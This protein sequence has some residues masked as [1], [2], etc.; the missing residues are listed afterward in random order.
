[1]RYLETISGGLPEFIINEVFSN[2][3]PHI[4]FISQ[5]IPLLFAGLTSKLATA[6]IVHEKA[7][8]SRGIRSYFESAC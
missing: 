2:P 8:C 7:S 6:T 4:G 3:V 1:M 5:P